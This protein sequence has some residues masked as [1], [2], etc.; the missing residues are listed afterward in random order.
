MRPQTT[1]IICY[2]FLTILIVTSVILKALHVHFEG[3]LKR[4]SRY[5][6]HYGVTK[7]IFQL[8]SL[9]IHP[10]YS[11]GDVKFDWAEESYYDS[12]SQTFQKFR[13]DFNSY[14]IILAMTAHFINFLL[15]MPSF[16]I[17][18]SV[19]AYR[20]C[21]TYR[22]SNLN[23]FFVIRSI[24][25]TN[26]LQF[27]FF[28]LAAFSI[29]F[30]MIVGVIENGY[31]RDISELNCTGDCD[32]VAQKGSRAVFYS[33]NNIFWNVFI[34][35]TTIG[36]FF[37]LILVRGGLFD[38]ISQFLFLILDNFFHFCENLKISKNFAKSLIK[39]KI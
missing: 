13:R 25:N 16:T 33:F 30:T 26:P 12:D 14:L 28:L 10:I 35:F 7:L 32:P 19:K 5:F 38:F 9:L 15:T 20:I 29:F 39:R 8:V 24:L 3:K 21:K 1:N 6:Q 22:V 4:D 2:V 11:A 17:W 31:L 27:T 37:D 34:T 36:N 18:Q 23:A